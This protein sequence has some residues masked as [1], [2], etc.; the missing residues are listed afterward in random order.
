M[1][2]RRNA[3]AF[4]KRLS[5]ENRWQMKVLQWNDYKNNRL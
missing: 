3:V 5:A 2:K 1:K 4:G